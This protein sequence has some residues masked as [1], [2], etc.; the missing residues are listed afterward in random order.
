[1]QTIT[2]SPAAMREQLADTEQAILA[3]AVTVAEPGRDVP[4]AELAWWLARQERLEIRGELAASGL[5]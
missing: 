4:H 5:L 1:M 2:L 3:F